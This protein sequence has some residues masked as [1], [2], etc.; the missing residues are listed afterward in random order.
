MAATFPAIEEL[1]SGA[2]D[3]TKGQAVFGVANNDYAEYAIASTDNVTA[4]LDSPSFELAATLPVGALTASQ[5]VEDAG[6]KTGQTVV[7]L[8]PVACYA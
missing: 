2:K 8:G 4:K 7:L 1:G 5:A 3:L 6:I